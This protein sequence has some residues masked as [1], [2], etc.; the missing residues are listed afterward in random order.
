[1]QTSLCMRVLK[2]ACAE[3]GNPETHCRYGNSDS[4]RVNTWILQSSKSSISSVFLDPYSYS[5]IHPSTLCLTN[6]SSGEGL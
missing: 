2:K 5:G 6:S 3:K 1:M 4:R